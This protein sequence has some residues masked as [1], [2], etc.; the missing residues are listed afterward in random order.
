[1]F[2]APGTKIYVIFHAIVI[3]EKSSGKV[4]VQL[5]QYYLLETA[6]VLQN[7]ILLD[8]FLLCTSR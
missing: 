1:M 3:L 7:D 4:L 5:N 6:V 8:F 2:M